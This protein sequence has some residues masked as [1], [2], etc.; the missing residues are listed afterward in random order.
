MACK[1]RTFA[2]F[3]STAERVRVVLTPVVRKNYGESV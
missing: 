1:N 3:A 2:P